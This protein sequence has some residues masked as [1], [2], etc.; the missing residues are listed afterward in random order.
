[1]IGVNK[2]SKFA[3]LD[4]QANILSEPEQKP[5]KAPSVPKPVI[6]EKAQTG[7]S[8]DDLE[9]VVL[10]IIARDGLINDTWDTAIEMK[11][12]HQVL[13]GV[14]KSLMVDR[15]VSDEPVSVTYWA[16]TDEGKDV[17]KNGSPEIQVFNAVPVG[18]I[19]VSDLN[20]SL[21]NVAKI[22]LG[23]CMK[24]KWLQ[25]KGDSIVK[26]VDSVEDETVKV[27]LSV[28]NGTV[29]S[30]EDELK[31]LKKR[32][33]VQQIT[34]KSLKITKGPEYSERRVR[35]MADLS[36]TMLGKKEEVRQNLPCFF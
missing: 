28:E 26:L 36:K 8:S 7:V 9:Q 22:G 12:D 31:N 11:L 5:T 14:L 21:G 13:V 2:T 3:V 27:L 18:G 17:A 35:K 32:K 30:S 16:L 24:N 15:Y 19:S 1:M 20:N 25:K 33:L 10:N 29:T 6:A 23:V 4:L 34:R